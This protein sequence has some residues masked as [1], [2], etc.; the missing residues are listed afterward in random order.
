MTTF[1]WCY[2]T[3]WL[4]ACMV[5]ATLM[6]KLRQQL[7]LFGENYRRFLA[8]PWKLISFAA[9]STG[10]V[11]I[12]PYTG[13]PTW[14]YFDAAFMAALTFTTAPWSIGILYRYLRGSRQH[15]GAYIAACLW[16]FSASWSYDGYLLLRD[17][18]Y[19]ETWLPNIAA[20]SVLYIAA[21]LMWSLEW[22]PARGVIFAFMRPD[23]PSPSADDHVFRVLAHA[24]PF[25]LLASACI[26]YFVW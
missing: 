26:L 13:D 7:S 25:M 12:A 10:I 5:A 3:I 1:L 20:S 24:L 16:L 22:Q 23:W 6:W 21:G 18:A 19:P 9:A 15:T 14:D 2:L 17:G 4:G 8:T 11:W